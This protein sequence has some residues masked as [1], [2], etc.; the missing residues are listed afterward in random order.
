MFSPVRD[1]PGFDL[2]WTVNIPRKESH[3]VTLFESTG[4]V[5]LLFSIFVKVQKILF[6]ADIVYLVLGQ[7]IAMENIFF[8][9]LTALRLLRIFSPCIK[10]LAHWESQQQ[11]DHDDSHNIKK[12]YWREDAYYSEQRIHR[13]C[14]PGYWQSMYKSQ[15]CYRSLG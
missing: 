2:E 8:V 10:F 3:G 4:K 15:I 14:Q 9:T 12:L 1:Y 5:F 7:S 11:L 13:Q 6:K